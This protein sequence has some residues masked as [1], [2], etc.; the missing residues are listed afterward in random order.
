MSSTQYKNKNQI[1]FETNTVSFTTTLFSASGES[2]T[3]ISYPGTQCDDTWNQSD[4]HS[5]HTTRQT[6]RSSSAPP[7][8]TK[9][10]ACT[11]S[12]KFTFKDEA[13]SAPPQTIQTSQRQLCPIRIN[14]A[15]E[16]YCLNINQHGLFICSVFVFCRN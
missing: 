1:T 4:H 5:N 16:S 14:C 10:T 12:R 6:F 2:F 9:L 7:R 3:T 13:A 15:L 11:F 8:Q